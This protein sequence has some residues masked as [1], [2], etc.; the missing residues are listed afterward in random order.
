MPE[1]A[2]I[3]AMAAIGCPL[4]AAGCSQE[5]P[6]PEEE[7]RVDAA[8]AAVVNGSPI[9]FADVELEA[10]SR[11]LVGPG[12]PF[13]IGHAEYQSVLDQLIDQRLMAQE[14][15]ARGLHLNET[16]R[17]RLEVARERVLG[18]LLVENLVAAE[19]TDER[20]REMYAEQVDL[21]Q[22]D[23]EV[24]LRHILTDTRDAAEAA[25]KRVL[26]G[27]DFSTVAFDVSRDMQTRIEGGELGYVAP[28]RMGEPFTS[29]IADT[30]TGEVSEPFE[31][32]EGWHII[33]VE[34]RRTPPPATLEE[35]RPDI[36]EFLTWEQIGR[37]LKKLRADAVI[38]PGSGVPR[39]Q[40][41][42]SPAPADEDTL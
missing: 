15:E 2:R 39:V 14:A 12:E 30:P 16:A 21:Q 18:N 41:E 34:D 19:V 23:D 38:S 40:P 6:A 4:F 33:K 31:G 17:R 8:I 5:A 1:I 27:E 13:G 22:L 35:M 10:V 42:T 7:I 29:R 9:Y 28:G 11:G 36:V 26:G 32:E 25:R 20:V 24:R 3:I 37:V